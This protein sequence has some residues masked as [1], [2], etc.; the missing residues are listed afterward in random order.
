MVS[1]SS[2][3]LYKTRND[4]DLKNLL[5]NCV[6]IMQMENFKSKLKML[7]KNDYVLLEPDVIKFSLF[8]SSSKFQEIIKF[9]EI[10][11]E[12]NLDKIKKL[13]N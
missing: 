10:V 9:G 11:V 4:I 7:N 1:V 13:Q 5:N 8:E 12:N 2:P 3:K 6:N